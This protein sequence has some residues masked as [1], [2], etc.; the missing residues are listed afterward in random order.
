MD[1][2]PLKIR[3]A[4]WAQRSASFLASKGMTPNH[5]SILSLVFSIMACISFSLSSY[6]RFAL[7]LGASFIQLRLICNLLDGMVAVEH[8]QSSLNGELYNDVPDRFADV[9]I[10]LGVSLTIKVLDIYPITPVNLA[11]LASCLAIITA[12]IRVLG[13]S[14]GTT[15]YFFGP[16][17]KQHRMFLVTISSLIEFLA[18]G[19]SY[20]GMTLYGALMLIATGSLYTIA[21]RLIKISSDLMRAENV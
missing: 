7:I 12:Y 13:K 2:R 18:Y 3:G 20:S 8:Q 15:S 21:S 17:A 10:I 9:F 6:S 1:R 14:L 19:T 11:W 5:I 4:R 16:M